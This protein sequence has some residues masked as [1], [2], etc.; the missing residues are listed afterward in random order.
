LL[1][2]IPLPHQRFLQNEWIFHQDELIFHQDQLTRIEE[3]LAQ[4]SNASAGDASREK[5]YLVYD[6]RPMRLLCARSF[7]TPVLLFVTPVLLCVCACNWRRLCVQ[8]NE[9]DK[10]SLIDAHI[11]PNPYRSGNRR[12]GVNQVSWREKEAQLQIEGG[13]EGTW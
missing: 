13:E 3:E 8:V 6:V 5:M 11:R 4:I 1:L 7:V 2:T 9:W 12:C 10:A